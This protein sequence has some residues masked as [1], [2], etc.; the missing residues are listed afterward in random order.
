MSPASAMFTA[1]SLARISVP[2][3]PSRAEDDQFLVPRFHTDRA[4]QNIPRAQVV[5]V[6]LARHFAFMDTPSVPLMRPD[7][8]VGANAPDFDR[9]A[10]LDGL[11]R[12]LLAVFDSVWCALF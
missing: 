6:R 4:A 10:F 2:T 12:Q 1:T 3:L 11:G 9:S 7:C 5:R 8:D